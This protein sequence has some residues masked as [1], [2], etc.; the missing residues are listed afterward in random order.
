MKLKILICL[1]SE[2]VTLVVSHHVS[3]RRPGFPQRGHDLLGLAYR[4]PG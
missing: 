3:H 4:R 1:F 2:N